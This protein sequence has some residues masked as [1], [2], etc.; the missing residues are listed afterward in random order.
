MSTLLSFGKRALL[1]FLCFITLKLGAQDA[2]KNGHLNTPSHPYLSLAKKY[3]K[4]RQK[5]SS[6]FWLQKTIALA[7][8]N[9]DPALESSTNFILGELYVT[10]QQEKKALQLFKRNYNYYSLVGN[11]L[12]TAISQH[13]MGVCLYRL[14]KFEQAHQ[15]YIKALEVAQ[16]RQ[17]SK[18]LAAVSGSLGNLYKL[19]GKYT[20]SIH[21]HFLALRI[22]EKS[23]N[24]KG[25][26]KS[27]INLGVLE[28]RLKNLDKA[29][30]Y[31]KKALAI[32]EELGDEKGKVLILNNLGVIYHKR[33]DFPNAIKYFKQIL[34]F[35]KKINNREGY[36]TNLHNLAILAS[37]QRDY[38]QAIDYYHQAIVVWK[39]IEY[40]PYLGKSLQ[41]LAMAYYRKKDFENAEKYAQESLEI[42][43]TSNA[44]KMITA[45]LKT[46]YKVYYA[47]AKYKEAFDYQKLYITYKDSLLNIT[48]TK[49]IAKLKAKYETERKEFQ[50][51]QLK[52][53]NRIK[54]LELQEQQSLLQIKETN[55]K[56]IQNDKKLQE[57]A[58][59]QEQMKKNNKLKT[60]RLEKEHQSNLYKAK[61]KNNQ[62]KI[63]LLNQENQLKASTLQNVSLQKR[64]LSILIMVIVILFVVTA[65]WVFSTFR[66][67]MRLAKEKLK[68]QNIISQ[69]ENLKN[70]LNPHFLMNN[71]NILTSLIYQNKSKAYDFVLKFSKLYS[72]LLV[73]KDNLLIE[74][75]EELAFCKLYLDLQKTR[76]GDALL[77]D[78]GIQNHEVLAQVPPLALHIALEN[79][80][81][82]N[83]ATPNTPLHISVTADDQHLIVQNNLQRKEETEVESTGIGIKNIMERYQL[84][85]KAQPVFTETSSHYLVK[86]PLV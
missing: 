4:K 22:R 40:K 66:Q 10:Y 45:A 79:A 55:L 56:L 49:Q 31:Y 41:N 19:Q 6:I 25:I 26:A 64:N 59:A 11:Q 69:F 53:Q 81:K 9:Q 52:K 7:Q 73:L 67:R 84:I 17:A 80:I 1:L 48:K 50:I 27:Y 15:Q 16:K 82:H 46:L 72:M 51:T 74:L 14:G 83:Q 78:Y 85:G 13:R 63:K 29:E 61:E 65:G 39:A 32:K 5:D 37:K 68:R 60:M 33:K 47:T 58:F 2:Y 34:A 12:N 54:K 30:A 23:G 76:F 44:K 24:K 28:S 21:Y 70:Q 8:K 43:R 62:Q 38:E 20:Q 77:I 35:N 86:L 18:L 57:L 42:V 71:L 3:M 75:K 36:A